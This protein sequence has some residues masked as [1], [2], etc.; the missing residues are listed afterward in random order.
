MTS[1]HKP[2]LWAGC[3]IAMRDLRPDLVFVITGDVWREFCILRA[4]WEE[5]LCVGFSDEC[6][7]YLRR[8]IKA[9]DPAGAAHW[10]AVREFAIQY[11]LSWVSAIEVDGEIIQECDESSAL[12]Y[13]PLAERK[14]VVIDG[15]GGLFDLATY[16]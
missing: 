4:A 12:R 7:T 2:H 6:I 11:G 16:G 5:P 3:V 9:G 13:P 15:T 14:R 1:S 8:A 10:K